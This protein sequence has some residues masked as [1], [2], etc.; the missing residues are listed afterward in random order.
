MQ[1]N[2]KNSEPINKL[3]NIEKELTW[4]KVH[5][6]SQKIRRI[7]KVK[8]I[9]KNSKNLET[10]EK[11]FNLIQLDIKIMPIVNQIPFMNKV[12]KIFCV[13]FKNFWHVCY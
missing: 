11:W 4:D 5:S 1:C 9:K 6:E 8:K 3:V 2:Q 13:Y 10:V 7:N 12:N